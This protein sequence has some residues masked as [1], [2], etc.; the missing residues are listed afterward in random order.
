MR[1]RQFITLLGAA[2]W[3]LAAKAQQQPAVPVIGYLSPASPIG[4]GQITL[5]AVRQGLRDTGFV[6]GQN[7]I[8]EYRWAEGQLDRLPALAAD[9]VRRQV[10]VIATTNGLAPAQAAMAATSTIPIVFQTA[11]DPVQLGVVASLNR[12]GGNV[13]GVTNSSTEISSKRL[14]VLLELAPQVKTVAQ[15]INAAISD[16]NVFAVNEVAAAAHALGRQHFVV[17]I[18]TAL[19]FE[20]TF[21]TLAERQ[22]SAAS[23]LSCSRKPGP[24]S[25]R[26][27]SSTIPN[28]SRP[29]G[30]ATFPRSRRQREHWP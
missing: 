15:I 19:D 27:G 14:A 26:S 10:S 20:A 22:A 9:L 16:T 23:G 1:R 13:T 3:P 6:E 18:R 12:P 30:A 24:G 25:K 8:V 4:V 7:V 28:S 29:R 11:S 5:T 2:A 21:A 17:G